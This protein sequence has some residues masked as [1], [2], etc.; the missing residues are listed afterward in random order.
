MSFDAITLADLQRAL[1]RCMQAH[2]PSDVELILHPD[3]NAMADVW[4]VMLLERRSEAPLSEV[5]AH[6]LE[7][8]RRWLTNPQ[9]VSGSRPWHTC[10]N[11]D[12][13]DDLTADRS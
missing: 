9:D 4:A 2:P 5:P 11:V 12:I 3:A 13:T 8:Y 6:V 7:A 10:T 1:D